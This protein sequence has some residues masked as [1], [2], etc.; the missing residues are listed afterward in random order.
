[1]LEDC[2]RITKYHT[3]ITP[4]AKDGILKA[5]RACHETSRNRNRNRVIH[6]AWATR[7]GSVT[8]TLQ[9]GRASHDVSAGLGR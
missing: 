8:V 7:P 3:G 2:E 4:A 9:G 5:L 6:D 1:M